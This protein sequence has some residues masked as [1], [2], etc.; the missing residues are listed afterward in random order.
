MYDVVY[1]AWLTYEKCK[2]L[3]A[4]KPQLERATLKPCLE[5]I[6]HLCSLRGERGNSHAIDGTKNLF[7]LENF[8]PFLILI[9]P[10]E[11]PHLRI[12]WNRRKEYAQDAISSFKC[13]VMSSPSAKVHEST[14][15]EVN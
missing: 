12:S 2:C 4:S 3:P 1:N 9:V 13:N 10:A 6:F 7:P 14:V 15:W 11:R 5:D 8:E